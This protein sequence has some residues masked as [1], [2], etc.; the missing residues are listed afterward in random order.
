VSDDSLPG[1]RA[2]R[3]VTADALHC[4]KEIIPTIVDTGSHYL[5][6]IKGNLLTLQRP[7]PRCST[8][9]RAALFLVAAGSDT[10]ASDTFETQA[11]RPQ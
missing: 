10:D 9:N 6:Q 7:S 1:R 11:Q 3:R 8:G 4:H 5:L 2:E